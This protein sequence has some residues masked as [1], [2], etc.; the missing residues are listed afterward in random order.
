MPSAPDTVCP[1][2]RSPLHRAISFMAA[3]RAH[4]LGAPHYQESA[5]PGF[6]S[7]CAPLTGVRPI[8]TTELRITTPISQSA[9]Q[10]TPTWRHNRSNHFHVRR[11]VAQR[12][13][14][15]TQRRVAHDRSKYARCGVE[16]DGTKLRR[17][18]IERRLKHTAWP[19]VTELGH[20][21]TKR[22]QRSNKQEAN[23]PPF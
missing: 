5:P 9:S 20:Q 14:Q 2:N 8:A 1:T 13:F 4:D 22:Q 12:S 3:I 18:S 16:C 7:R 19:A 17:S 23:K 10:P 21:T 11:R 15:S 6:W